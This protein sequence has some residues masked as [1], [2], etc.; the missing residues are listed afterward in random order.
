MRAALPVCAVFMLTSQ[1]GAVDE[2]LPKILWRTPKKLTTQ[3]W[4]CGPGGCEGAPAAPFHF[5]KEES[6]GT[7]PKISVRDAKGRTWSI[8]F[9]AE[10]IPECFSSRFVTALG[11][12]AEPTYFVGRGRIEGLMHLKRARRVIHAEGEFRKG[13]FE[14]RGQK[15]FEF[16]DGQT[17]SWADNPFNGTH[18]LAGLKV[19]M[20]LLS[21]WD[22]KDARD[23]PGESNNNVFRAS[24]GGPPVLL[25][26]VSDWGASLGRWGAPRRRDRSDCSGYAGDTPRFI[27]GIRNGEIEFGYWGKHAEDIKGGI[28]VGDVA[29]LVPYLDRISMEELLTGLRAS[30]ATERQATCWATSIGNR[31]RQLK[32]V[33]Q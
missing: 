4:I 14:G 3:D 33:I 30:G 17:W 31:I 23:G 2:N 25:Y 15:G 12:T 24:E 11:Y 9:G 27:S 26:A 32:A 1:A 5:L 22:A 8:K 7:N 18:E 20:M 13:R 21:N 19:V 29:W 10:V 6:G 28:S 16:L